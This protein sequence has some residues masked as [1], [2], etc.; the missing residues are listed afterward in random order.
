MLKK[1]F[2]GFDAVWLRPI[3]YDLLVY[4][5]SKQKH[6]AYFPIW[7]IF[8]SV[9]NVGEPWF[10][11][12]HWFLVQCWECQLANIWIFAYAGWRFD[13]DDFNT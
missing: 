12:C 13:S 6:L 11:E 4:L 5:H 8:H 1:K 9:A 3:V 7:M 2:I 10:L